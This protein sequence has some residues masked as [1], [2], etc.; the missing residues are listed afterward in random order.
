MIKMTEINV[1]MIKKLRS[2]LDIL[3]KIL[4]KRINPG[5]SGKKQVL[6]LNQMPVNHCQKELLKLNYSN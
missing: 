1:E 2:N 6:L 4:S 5:L 3:P